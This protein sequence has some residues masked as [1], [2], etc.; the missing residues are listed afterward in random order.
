MGIEL[1]PFNLDQ[2]EDGLQNKLILLKIH[3]LTPTLAENDI[4]RAGVWSL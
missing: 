4:A 2:V 3:F 1:P